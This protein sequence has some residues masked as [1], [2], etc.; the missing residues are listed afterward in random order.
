MI[1]TIKIQIVAF[2]TLLVLTKLNPKR[3]QGKL[4]I[5]QI[6][7]KSLFKP[8]FFQYS[9]KEIKRFEGF[10]LI[11]VTTISFKEWLKMKK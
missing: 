8:D 4:R 9:Y 1:R 11:C 10:Y 6:P 5:N 3:N 7:D 2:D